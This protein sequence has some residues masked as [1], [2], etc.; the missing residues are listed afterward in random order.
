MFASGFESLPASCSPYEFD[1][2]FEPGL[3][4]E[5]ECGSW[6]WLPDSNKRQTVK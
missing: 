3:D 6:S 5:T 4:S 2:G 1:A